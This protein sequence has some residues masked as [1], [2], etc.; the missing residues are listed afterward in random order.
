MSTAIP[1]P[2][3]FDRNDLP[4][5]VTCV[6]DMEKCVPVKV[7]AEE[8]SI[9]TVLCQS[10]LSLFLSKNSQNFEAAGQRWL[11]P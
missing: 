9:F 3:P 1:I 10:L 6:M 7:L 11:E 2:V 8:E 4:S 5:D